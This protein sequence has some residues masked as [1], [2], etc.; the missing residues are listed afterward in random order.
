MLIGGYFH[1]CWPSYKSCF[2]EFD[3]SLTVAALMSPDFLDRNTLAPGF[4]LR[5]PSILPFQFAPARSDNYDILGLSFA[6][7]RRPFN[8]DLK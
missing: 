2:R 1:L 8:H 5:A 4:W 6:I 7:F 3:C